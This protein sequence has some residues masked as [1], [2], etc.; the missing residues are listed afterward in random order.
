MIRF[1]YGKN[2]FLISQKLREIEAS[3]V[4][5]DPSGINLTRID[6]ASLTVGQFEQAMTAMPFLAEKR[7]VIIKNLQLE[8]MDAELKNKISD[9]LLRRKTAPRNDPTSLSELRGASN[10]EGNNQTDL[11]FVEMGE[12]DKRLKLYKDLLKN[13]EVVFCDQLQGSALTR[14]V[15]EQFRA[16]GIEALPL[17]ADYLI[18]E[19]GLDMQRLSSEITKIS[20]YVRSQKRKNLTRGDIDNLACVEIDPNIFQFTDAIAKRDAKTATR[21]LY[22]FMQKGE[23]EQKLLGTLAFQLRTLVIIRDALDRNI[24]SQTLASKAKIAPFVITKNLSIA[25]SRPL[26]TFIAMY[27]QLRRTDSAIKSGEM[28]PSLAI[29]IL[30]TT[31]CR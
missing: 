23:S 12:P 6:G 30:V 11:V 4:E 26:K 7:L 25:R 21:L 10:K 8:N 13:A 22:E 24:P 16:E 5:S 20:L 31:L 28:I 29:D 19:V 9:R 1:I 15:T 14:W 17:D 18:A 27:D 2:L 3:F